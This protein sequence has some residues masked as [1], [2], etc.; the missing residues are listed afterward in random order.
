VLQELSKLSAE[1]TILDN[2][3]CLG[4]CRDERSRNPSEFVDV[5]LLFRSGQVYSPSERGWRTDSSGRL[6]G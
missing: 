4:D 6:P 1:R 5:E 2:Y 3:P